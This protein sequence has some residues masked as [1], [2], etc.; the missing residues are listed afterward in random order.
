M[1]AIAG[2]VRLQGGGLVVVGGDHAFSAGG[3]RHTALEDIL[4]VISEPGG[5]RPKPSL[6]WSWCSTARA[7]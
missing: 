5:E 2:Y 6:R 7:Q 4:P 1:E 3:Y